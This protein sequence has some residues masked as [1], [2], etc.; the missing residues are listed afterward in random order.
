MCFFWPCMAEKRKN[1]CIKC[2]VNNS[3][4]SAHPVLTTVL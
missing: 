3:H 2:V 1:A 4:G